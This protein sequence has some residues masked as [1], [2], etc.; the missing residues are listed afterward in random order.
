MES[1]NVLIS[2]SHV[3]FCNKKGARLCLPSRKGGSVMS[4]YEL[5][6]PE[7]RAT[8][9]T[10]LLW[11]STPKCMSCRSYDPPRRAGSFLWAM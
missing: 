8:N 1:S 2:L 7:S 3:G 10:P 9:N 4:V 6:I 11:T 5:R